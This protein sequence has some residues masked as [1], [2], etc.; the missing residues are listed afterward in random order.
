MEKRDITSRTDYAILTA[1]ISKA[2]HMSTPL[3]SIHDAT[4]TF[5]GK[6]LF[7]EITLHISLGEKI[8]LVGRNGSGKSTLFK[9]IANELELDAGERF[10]QPGT[11]IG[12]LPQSIEATPNTSIY[13]YVKK[14]LPEEKQTDEFLYEIDQV[15]APLYLTGD[16]LLE[17]LSGGQLRRT[18]LARALINDP[19]I[20]LLDEPTNHLDIEAIEWLEGY[21]QM[22]QGGLVCISHD[23]AFLKSISDKTFWLDRGAIRNHSRGYSDFERWSGELIEQ[24][25]R[26]LVKL[27]RKVEEENSWLQKGV[28]A[29]R[30]RNQQRL[31]EVY[32]LRDQLKHDKSKLHKVRNRIQLEPLDPASATKMVAEMEGVC[33]SF[34]DLKILDQFTMRI[35]R[36]DRIGIVGKNGSGKSTFLKLITKQLE[37]DSGRLRIGKHLEFSYFEQQRESLDPEE[38]LWKTLC[39]SGGDHLQVG[40]GTRHVVAY[41]KDFLFDPKQARSQVGSLSGGEMNRLLLAKILAKPGDVLILDEPTN[42]LDMDTLDMLQEILSDYKGTLIIVSHDRDFIDRIVTRTIIF[43]GEGKVDWYVGGYSDYL[44]QKQGKSKKTSSK[45]SAKNTSDKATIEKPKAT[46]TKLTYK[47]QR[48]LDLLPGEIEEL[49]ASIVKMEQQLA[50]PDFYRDHPD[51]F[52]SI[53]QELAPAK[54]LLNQ[55]EERWIELESMA[56]GE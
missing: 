7:T 39:P 25:A 37:K 32:R 23:R 36:G 51:A 6:P 47:L 42:D 5:G 44:S 40:K 10:E 2:R 15:L 49:A 8:C 26:E 9:V 14:G 52:D 22:F 18:A 54:E 56:A 24:E 21:L 17:H 45:A 11:R 43:E 1:E 55:K 19:D 33:K 30:K 4:V 16:M 13:D 29:R 3:L 20:L 27:A 31:K 53:M 38:T 48:E 34:G 46:S 28:T 12:Y 50:D 35:M 41:L